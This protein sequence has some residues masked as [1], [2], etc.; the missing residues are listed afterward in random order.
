MRYKRQSEILDRGEKVKQETRRFNDNNGGTIP[1]RSK[2]EAEDYRYFPD[3]D[4]PAILFT[5]EQLKEIAKKVPLLPQQRFDIYTNQ[6]GLPPADAKL[7]L[8]KKT[9]AI[10]ITNPVKI[11]NN[12][13]DT[14]SL[15][16]VELV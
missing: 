16:I 9:T 10:S 13:K 2:E 4:I 6:Y 3:P 7:L 15:F 12:Y 8:T 1:M 14:A 11:Y 5:E